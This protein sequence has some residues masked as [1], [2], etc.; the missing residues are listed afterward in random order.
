MYQVYVGLRGHARFHHFFIYLP[1]LRRIFFPL[2][3]C[4]DPHDQ[5]TGFV[6]KTLFSYQ[7]FTE[8]QKN[9]PL[10]LEICTGTV[11]CSFLS[12]V[13]NIILR[14]WKTEN[15][16]FFLPVPTFIHLFMDLE[17]SWKVELGEIK[18]E[19]ILIIW[20]SYGEVSGIPVWSLHLM[21][22]QNKKHQ[23]WSVVS[24]LLEARNLQHLPKSHISLYVPVHYSHPHQSWYPLSKKERDGLVGCAKNICTCSF[25][26]D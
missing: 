14:N 8:D 3:F 26:L 13:D 1:L 5:S 17:C 18:E 22:S 7:F 2:E 12:R 19:K 24:K 6:S 21:M 4:L 16:F 15:P 25:Q 10:L 11:L 23:L 20:L 9:G